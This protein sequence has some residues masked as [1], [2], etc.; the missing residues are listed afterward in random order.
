MARQPSKTRSGR[1]SGATKASKANG[2]NL[3]IVESPAKARTINRYLGDDYF[4]SASMGHVRDLP[5]K[6]LGVDLEHDFEP[7][8]EVIG[9][10]RKVL[11]E[12]KRV[13]KSAPAVYLA[14]DLDREGEAIAWHLAEELGVPGERIRRVVFNE[15]TKSAI[16]EAFSHPRGIELNRVNAQ[17]ARRILDRIVGYQISPLLWRK[18][19]RGLSAGRVQSVSVRLIVDREKEIDAF[20]PA[21]FWRIGGTFTVELAAAADLAGQWQAFCRQRDEKG[22]T[23][24]KDAQ[25]DWLGGHSSFQADLA[26]WRGQKVDLKD[27][28]SAAQ[29]VAALGLKVDEPI[30]SENPQ[31]KGA[32]RNVVALNCHLYDQPGRP[33]SFAVADLQERRSQSRPPGSFTTAALQQ[34]ASTQLR[35]AASRTMRVA[36]DLYEGVEVPGEGSVGLIT[37]MRTDSLNLSA[38]SLRMART[39][40]GEQFGPR[41]VPEQPNRYAAGGRAQEA[42][43]AIRPTDVNRRPEDLR[44]VLSADQWK[45]Y[46]LIWRR[47][48]AC[49]MPPAEWNV[50]EAVVAADTAAGRAEFK[51]VGRTLVFDGFLRVSGLSGRG[52]D[53]I[54]PALQAGQPVAPIDLEATQ[55]FTQ[56]PPRYTEASLVKALEAE[57]IG[58][59]STYAS[60]IQTIQ[61]RGYV[62][63]IDRRFHPTGLGAK[64]TE[65]LIEHFPRVMDVRF[66]AHMEDE[67]DKI[68]E[69]DRDWVAVLRE[70]YG[71]FKENLDRAAE[72]MQHVKA[73]EEPSDYACPSCG[74]PMVYRWSQNGRYLACTGYPDCKETFPV[75]REGK[76]IEPKV[77]AGACPK[78]GGDMMLRRSRFGVFLGCVNYPQCDGTRPCDKDGNPKR[79]VKEAE[80]TAPCPK[81]GG[82]MTVKR[83]GRRAFLG[84]ANYPQCDG[85]A[86]I[87]DDVALE[88]PPKVPPKPTGLTCP[89]C[90][91]KELVLRQGPRGEFVSCSGFP[92]CRFS[93]N[94]DKLDAVRAAVE[95]GKPAEEIL[96]MT[97]R[98]KPARRASKK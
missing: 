41:Y 71:P 5:Q 78:C 42:H 72:Q 68:E 40:I 49:Q 56:P 10:R 84:C 2:R 1:G 54:L 76:K 39:F 83:K 28:D 81:C 73:E 48:V 97:A 93:F 12:L 79:I 92:R 14:T 35:F 67:L 8:Y 13:A 3:V 37:Y 77:V 98:G 16:Q 86:P 18:V 15:I 46:D 11:A 33:A 32:A 17:Q 47:F 9:G 44:G 51:A 87:P 58:R 31:G 23:P 20:E 24:T 43:E 29:I 74:K 7:T 64:V 91:K 21:E 66:T 62:E 60:I 19:A 96:A 70:F 53:Q 22:N 82:T 55:S 38:D 50:T 90:G 59:P 36:Q 27:A 57:G 75:D 65:K 94:L 69:A 61:D 88:A 85:T 26:S 4:V 6:D 52:G 80:L 63:Q 95:A 45:L 25:R 89:K 30:R 34:A